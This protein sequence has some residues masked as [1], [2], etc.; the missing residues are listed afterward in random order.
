M[1]KKSSVLRAE[2]NTRRAP[3]GSNAAGRASESRVQL[4]KREN[5]TTVSCI[6]IVSTPLVILSQYALFTH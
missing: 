3:R 1:S 4:L 5:L 6:C 2:I